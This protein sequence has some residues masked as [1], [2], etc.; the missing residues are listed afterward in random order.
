MD[1]NQLFNGSIGNSA[2]RVAQISRD[3]EERRQAEFAHRATLEAGA[4]ASVEQR[5]LLEQQVDLL[6]TQNSQLTDNYNKLKEMYDR[7]V[8]E[9]EEAKKDLKKSWRFNVCM[10]VI[11][12]ISMLAAV[13]G[14]VMSLLGID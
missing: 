8:R 3:F 12:V 4:K 11:A 10:L 1:Y 9:A 7:Q 5:K 13:A 2:Q 6:K 14:P